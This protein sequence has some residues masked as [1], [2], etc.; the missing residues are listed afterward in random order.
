MDDQPISFQYFSKRTRGWEE[1]WHEIYKILQTVS[2]A[3]HHL[4]KE[5]LIQTINE[6]F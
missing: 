6:I 4:L 1:C 3:M 2:P 5:L